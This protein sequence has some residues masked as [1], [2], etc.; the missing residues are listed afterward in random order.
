LF[1]IFLTPIF[2][3][4]IQR[5]SETR[6]F[7]AGATRWAGSTLLA[8]LAGMGF[9]F[10]VAQLGIVRLSLGL[11]AGG[12]VGC[13]AALAVLSLHRIIRGQSPDSPPARFSSMKSGLPDG[14]D[15]P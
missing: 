11:K 5:L 7:T 4:V 3:S 12:S 6:M 15:Q 14:D 8:G 1:G 9:G 10:L 13:L 2:F